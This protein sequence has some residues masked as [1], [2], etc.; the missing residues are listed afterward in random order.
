MSEKLSNSG[1]RNLRFGM[2][3][4]QGQVNL[5]PIQQWPHILQHLSDDSDDHAQFKKKIRQYNN[6]LAFTSIGVDVNN[7]TIQGSGPASFHIH[8]TLHHLMEALI[9]PDDHQSSY[10]QLYIY[11]PQEA[12]DRCVQ[13]NPQLNPRELLDLHNML[14]ASHPYAEVYQQ[15][16]EVMRVSIL[17]ISF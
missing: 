14:R 1:I 4:L 6:A 12:T 2:C 11:D 9:P 5:P 10:A 8:G 3:C 16:Y 17:Y 13:C 15:A 7:H